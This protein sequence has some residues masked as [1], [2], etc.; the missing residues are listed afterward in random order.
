MHVQRLSD[1]NAGVPPTVTV[2]E[3]GAHGP[4]VTGMH[5]CGVRTPC[6][7]D[8]A[9]ATC[10]FDSVV[11]MP[12]GAMFMFGAW[13]LIRATGWLLPCV[14]GPDGTTVSA[15]GVVPKVHASWA[16]LT[17]IWAIAPSPAS[18]SGPFPTRAAYA[19]A[20]PLGTPESLR[21]ADRASPLAG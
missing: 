20:V 19:H 14:G 9:E 13:S 4:A 2:G 16:P 3:P 18:P 17:T 6:A 12:N 5:G 1:V 15:D 10:G 21:R 11:H 7:A 8:V